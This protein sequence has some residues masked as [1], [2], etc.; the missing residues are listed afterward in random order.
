MKKFNSLFNRYKKEFST[1]SIVPLKK[2]GNYPNMFED[3]A[4]LERD[5]F[6]GDAQPVDDLEDDFIQ[7]GFIGLG[8]FSKDTGK[9]V[10]YVYGFAMI[11][12]DN[13]EDLDFNNVKFFDNEFKNNVETG[14][15]RYLRK[16]FTPKST[17]YVNNILIDKQYR[18]T[19][20]SGKL[21]LSFLEFIQAKTNYEYMLFN[22]FPDT[23]KLI[24][25]RMNKNNSMTFL[26]K[27]N[28]NILIKI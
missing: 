23:M 17:I 20:Y 1:L 16:T 19:I 28:N 25:N 2:R 22:A 4:I 8:L 9:I 3:M 24:N 15:E 12:E 18:N 6:R 21:I 13:M 11:F 14:G 7:R 27:Q 5:I 26:A 10:G